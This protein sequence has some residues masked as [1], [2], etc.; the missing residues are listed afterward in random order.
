MRFIPTLYSPALKPKFLFL[1]VLCSSALILCTD[2][3]GQK[4]Q[5]SPATQISKIGFVDHS[6][7]R[8][9]Y[10]A[11]QKSKDSIAKLHTTNTA[12]YNISLSDLQKK[13]EK[14]LSLDMSKGGKNQDK[15]KQE[16]AAQKEILLKNY[17]KQQQELNVLRISITGVHETRILEVM[18]TVISQK[19][20]TDVKPFI[21]G[22][23]DQKGEDITETVIEKLNQN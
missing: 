11:F 18:N 15:I 9:S 20:F 3:Y 17:Q 4:R 10:T 19:G 23:K 5:L 1:V 13:E 7:V 2:T 21:K 6:K 8:S 14:A 22:D 16:Y 12:T